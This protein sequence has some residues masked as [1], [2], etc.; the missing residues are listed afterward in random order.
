[1]RWVIKSM[2]S[3]KYISSKSGRPKTF[4]ILFSIVYEVLYSTKL[5]TDLG[6]IRDGRFFDRILR[7]FIHFFKHIIGEKTLSQLFIPK[8]NKNPQKYIVMKNVSSIVLNL[9]IQ[10]KALRKKYIF[11]KIVCVINMSLAS[12]KLFRVA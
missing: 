12:I 2:M 8:Q 3:C 1:M 11:E 7:R 4:F 6:K 9:K 5:W 10:M